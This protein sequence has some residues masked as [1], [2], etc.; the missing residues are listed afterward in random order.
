[1]K[2]NMFILVY[3]YFYLHKNEG[4]FGNNHDGR[5]SVTHVIYIYDYK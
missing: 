1:M 5:D 3:F 4:L 2:L